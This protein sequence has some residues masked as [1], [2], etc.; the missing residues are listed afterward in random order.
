MA[1]NPSR[2]NL[3]LVRY[4]DPESSEYIYFWTEKQGKT[5]VH[6]SPMF[7]DFQSA[8]LW[9]KELMEKFEDAR[10]YWTLH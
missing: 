7:D 4:R 1:D 10:R 5:Y 6:V 2:L 3:T 9:H 8:H